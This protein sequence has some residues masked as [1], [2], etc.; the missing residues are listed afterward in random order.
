[1]LSIFWIATAYI[2][3]GLLLASSLSQK[4]P[5]GHAVGVHM[6]FWAL[7]VLV[8]G[9][10]LGELAGIHQRFGGLWSWFGHQG[11]EFLE[12]GRFW[13]IILVGLLFFNGRRVLEFCG[14]RHIRI[15]IIVGV[16]PMVIASG[17][18]YLEIRKA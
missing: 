3:G 1:M 17:L 2:A 5:R 4:E 9:S 16:V 10:L 14:C 6:L 13:Q 7:V 8:A 18:T 12:L 11:W 15:L